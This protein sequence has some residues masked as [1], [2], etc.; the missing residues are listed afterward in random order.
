MNAVYAYR[1]TL[2][3]GDRNISRYHCNSLAA[4]LER[5]IEQAASSV[6]AWFICS[7]HP[8]SSPSLPWRLA[9]ADFCLYA[10]R[11]NRRCVAAAVSWNFTICCLHDSRLSVQFGFSCILCGHSPRTEDPSISA[12]RRQLF[13]FGNTQFFDVIQEIFSKHFSS[14]YI[15]HPPTNE[16]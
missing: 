3:C 14:V 8:L 15:Y 10:S 11:R 5:D 1:D 13:Y 16:S 4:I 12:R 9:A 2:V 7:F 6:P